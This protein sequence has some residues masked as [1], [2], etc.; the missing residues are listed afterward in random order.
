M[1]FFEITLAEEKPD[2]GDEGERI[3]RPRQLLLNTEGIVSIER[4]IADPDQEAWFDK[5]AGSLVTLRNGT[6]LKVREPYQVLK[7]KLGV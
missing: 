3:T 4:H 5:I 7:L 6:I 1:A 2:L